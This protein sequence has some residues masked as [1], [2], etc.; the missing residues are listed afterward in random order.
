MTWS[1]LKALLNNSTVVSSG[2]DS[3]AFGPAR[4]PAK[5]AGK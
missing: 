5:G 2:R 4:E 3:F 1:Q